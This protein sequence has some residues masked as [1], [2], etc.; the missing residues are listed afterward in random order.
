MLDDQAT[1][2]AGGRAAA[3]V[4]PPALVVLT[5]ASGFLA[6]HVTRRL[7]EDGYRVRATL[8]APAREA[9]VRAAVLPGLPPDA[10]EHLAFARADLDADEGWA[11]AMSGA[12]ALIH[13]ASPFPMAQ[14]RDRDALVRPAVGGT[15]R[16]LDAAA[17]AG[18]TRVVLTSSVVAI[19]HEGPPALQDETH[20][21]DPDAPTT[22]PYAR[23]KTLAERAAWDLARDRGL[24]LTVINPGFILG[25]LLGGAAGTSADLV[26][27]LLKARDPML[28][29][30]DFMA[31][32][33]RDVAAAHVL[34]LSRPATAGERIAAVAGALS[35]P[36]MARVLK[37]AYPDRRIPTRIAPDWLIRLMSLAVRDL[38]AAVPL[39]GRPQAVSNAKA[40]A[41]LGI[42]FIPPEE[43]LRAT[44]RDLIA[45]G[46]A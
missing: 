18:M 11:A 37:A 23:S 8:R 30:L 1:S 2:Q 40:R 20:W 25:P 22:T 38:R 42:D 19:R 10:G 31:V 46:L 12:E 39:L 3:S 17:A 33:A 45:Q 29:N 13:T 7:L 15:R 26:A 16:A 34:A 35:F 4:L 24:R 36:A 9:E 6:R 32:D 41:L 5:G 28:P 27:R 43:A 21:A 14:P 44:A